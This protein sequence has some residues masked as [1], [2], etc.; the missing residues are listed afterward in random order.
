MDLMENYYEDI[1]FFDKTSYL[2]GKNVIEDTDYNQIKDYY[3]TITSFLNFINYQYT[4][5]DFQIKSY[6][7]KEESFSIVKI[8]Q[9]EK[10]EKFNEIYPKEKEMKLKIDKIYN[11]Y[12]LW[13]D[14]KKYDLKKI[15]N[16]ISDG[17]EQNKKLE[18][19]IKFNEDKINL[20]KKILENENENK[21]IKLIAE[22][23]KDNMKFNTKNFGKISEDLEKLKNDNIFITNFKINT[24]DI[25]IKEIED[26]KSIIINTITDKGTEK[27][28]GEFISDIGRVSSSN[29]EAQLGIINGKINDFYKSEFSR[30]SLNKIKQYLDELKRINKKLQEYENDFQKKKKIEIEK[31]VE[32]KN[33]EEYYN[34]ETLI[35]FLDNNP[36]IIGYNDIELINNQFKIKIEKYETENK[37]IKGKKINIQKL[38]NKYTDQKKI[39]LKEKNNKKIEIKRTI[40]GKQDEFLKN[41]LGKK[42]IYDYNQK[43]EKKQI[44]DKITLKNMWKNQIEVDKINI[45]KKTQKW[46]KWL[47]DKFIINQYGGNDGSYYVNIK[48]LNYLLYDVMMQMNK[49][50]INQNEEKKI[51]ENII[52]N[53]EMCLENYIIYTKYISLRIHSGKFIPNNKLSVSKINEIILKIKS[54]IN[55]DLYKKYKT[56]LN[57][58]IARV[59]RCYN[60]MAQQLK[61]NKT[62]YI[63]IIESNAIIDILLGYHL[64]TRIN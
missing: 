35:K 53:I 38:E 34:N 13:K 60:Q 27:Y 46:Q 45:D 7:E 5:Q 30:Q 33:L 9:K 62:Q 40:K 17:I 12:D 41:I 57:I 20:Y 64:I 55:T 15:K 1:S 56:N 14:K 61:G 48:E 2:Y 63:D 22:M 3:F 58:I 10:K 49:I 19:K 24:K 44:D 29:I 59:E 36:E 32:I 11:E 8:Y 54:I 28:P 26:N 16:E 50:N 6:D 31:N 23:I 37:E 4:N 47:T 43:Y 39:Y 18:N 51:F 21:N 25:L 52:R 42:Q